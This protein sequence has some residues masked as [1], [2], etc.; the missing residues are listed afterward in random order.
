M[1]ER[2]RLLQ[3]TLHWHMT[4]E[5]HFKLRTGRDI[6]PKPHTE[7]RRHRPQL[8]GPPPRKSEPRYSQ[9]RAADAARGGGG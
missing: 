4:G 5:R 9:Q 2:V 1:R 6:S 8:V 3:M 7:T